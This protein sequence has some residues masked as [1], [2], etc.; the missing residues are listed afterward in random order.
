MIIT[1]HQPEHLPWLGFFNKMAKAETYVILDNVP[2]RK[3]YVQ[4]RNRIL[5]TNGVQW[6][7]VPV[8]IG[9]H[10]EGTIK[11]T[12]IAFES[13]PK[14]KTKYLKTLEQ[15]YK[16]YPYFD[17]VFSDIECVINQ[18][19][20]SISEL[21]FSLLRLF[22]DKMNIRPNYVFAS[23]LDVS[24]NKS[25]LILDICKA[26]N[27]DTYI[28]GPSGRR[29]LD[30]KSFMAASIEVVYNDYIHPEYSQKR[31]TEFVS[32]LSSVDLFMNLGYEKAYH[33]IM[34]GNEG[35]SYE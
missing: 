10:I 30:K 3:N 24:G 22:A 17:E 28:A 31:T 26:L 8:L 16:K 18:N 11:T 35:L 9:G 23:D 33:V 20:D 4:N 6:I 19:W 1:I 25:D 34:S 15:S 32:H 7:V 21:N 14:W 13:Q 27:A 12:R 5:G 29:Y 2:F